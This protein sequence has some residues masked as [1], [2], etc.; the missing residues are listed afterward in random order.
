MNVYELSQDQLD[1]LKWA[2]FYDNDAQAAIPENIT[3]PYDI[4]NDIIYQHYS[5]IEFVEEDFL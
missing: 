4:P 1:F 5:G 2:Y 3:E